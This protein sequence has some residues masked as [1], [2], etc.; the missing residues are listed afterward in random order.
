MN[1]VYPTIQSF[2][3]A[4][5]PAVALICAVLLTAAPA[6]AAPK[7]DGT[8]TVWAPVGG[9]VP[10]STDYEVKLRRGD[11]VWHPFVY[12]TANQSYDK[13]LD[14]E[15]KY[16]KLSFLN[17][18]SNNYVPPANNR[19]TY[20]HSWTNFDFSG[21]PIEVEITVRPGMD[22]LTLPL[23]SCD[24]LPS[25]LG[26]TCRI[27]GENTVRFIL[28]R[29]AKF[30]V[31]PNQREALKKL[32]TT[33]QKQAFEG[34]RNPLFI[35]AREPET[36][37]P[38]RDARG[39]LVIEPGRQYGPE[40]F[41]K[42][43]TIW[44]APGVHDYSRF[45]TRDPDHYMELRTGQTMYLAG[46]AYVYGQIA[47]EIKAP[48]RDMPLLRGRGTLSNAKGRWGGI[49]YVKTVER[50]VRMEGIQV[51]DAHAHLSHSIAPMKNIAVVGA[52]HGNTDG[53]TREVPASESYDGWHVE[54][55]FIMAA[56]TNLKM[57]GRGRARDCTLWQLDNAEP[58]WIRR[59]NGCIVDDIRII[60]Y[61][62]WP[63]TRGASRQ[64]VNFDAG[65][66]EMK[67]T[68]V[69][70]ITIEAPYVP[71]LFLMTSDHDGGGVAYEN[72]L[73]KNITVNTPHIQAKSPFG[74][75]S[76]DGGRIGRVIFRNLVVNGVKV[77][78]ENCREYFDLRPGVT[79][80]TEIVFE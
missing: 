30:A 75:R 40:D 52:W 26:I 64:T 24:V 27:V 8:V 57:G 5:R 77:T 56:D 44:F 53:P 16:V 62:S 31:V 54:D 41:A 34:Y 2:L 42:A 58:L 19:D 36:G 48:V 3:R 4:A 39:T 74:P 76:A 67:N 13:T 65:R 51:T 15:G 18:H 17:L 21:G 25:T 49:P 72:V 35:F 33:E 38:A 14:E 70:N 80:G 68:L 60:A 10:A 59:S 6:G 37:V 12:R 43:K 79:I 22:G 63:G 69:S 78:A 29:P 45:N 1:L 20:A 11:Q 9:E 32:A 7:A 28:E 61:N 73:F 71:L 47:S 23:R 46:G 66:G 50:N 55:C